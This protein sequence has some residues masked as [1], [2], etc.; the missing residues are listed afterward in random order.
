MKT[1]MYMLL[2]LVSG[3]LGACS[4][5]PNNILEEE[6]KGVI[7]EGKKDVVLVCMGNDPEVKDIANRLRDNI[8]VSWEIG[9]KTIVNYDDFQGEASKEL[10]KYI[11]DKNIYLTVIANINDVVS[12][13]YPVTLF[14]SLKFYKRDFYVIATGDEK[15][16][17][18]AML[19]L[20]GVYMEKGYYAVNY[21]K[22]QHYRIFPSADPYA[23]ENM[24]GKGVTSIALNVAS[25][26]ALAGAGQEPDFS[27]NQ[28]MADR[29]ALKRIEI[30]NRL[31]GY[32]QGGG[33]MSYSIEE[34]P[35]RLKDGKPADVIIDNDWIIDAYNFQ[36]YSKN[37]N[38][39]LSVSTGTGNGFTT[40]I[41]SYTSPKTFDVYAYIWNLMQECSS[42][43]SIHSDGGVFREVSYQ[44][45]NVNHGASYTENSFWKVSVAVAPTKLAESPW[46]AFKVAFSKESSTNVSYKTL[47]MD[48]ICKGQAGGGLY[49][50]IWRFVPGQ[51]YDKAPAFTYETHKNFRVI[52]AVQAMTPNYVTWGGW[53]LRQNYLD[54]I[55]NSMKLHKQHCIYTLESDALPGVVTVSIRDVLKLQKTQVHYNCGIRY[56]HQSSTTGMGMGK[57]VWIDFGQWMN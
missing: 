4:K 55:N 25:T 19:S 17:H 27:F 43:I 45:Q 16:Q 15:V 52:D 6:R 32:D 18:K 22:V 1:R 10:D 34:S 48:A 14:R 8:P 44:P 41:R 21:D 11:I 5:D 26:K 37:N 28:Q 23:K 51:F 36:I 24:I 35:Y 12:D 2:L 7:G 29:E 30:Y 53:T 31:Y 40:N 50:K 54:H 57:M 38:C 20:I 3:F 56:G 47:S 39:I 42:E 13:K 46:E 9:E 33:S 49:S